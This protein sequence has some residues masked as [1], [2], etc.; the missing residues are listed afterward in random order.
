[1]TR[2]NKQVV[3]RC[4]DSLCSKIINLN[5]NMAS[6]GW[7]KLLSLRDIVRPFIKHYLGNGQE[8]NVWHDTWC[9][10]G[11]IDKF[12]T[13]RQIYNAGFLND[14]TVNKLYS[15]GHL[16]FPVDW[17]DQYPVLIEASHI[18]LHPSKKDEVKWLHKKKSLVKFSINKAWKDLRFQGED[19][20]WCN[21]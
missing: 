18:V 2:D 4:H 14:D 20:P 1:M 9:E 3:M 6:W 11:P 5:D 10:G 8:T 16:Q 19:V 21:V 12:V 13:R 7:N 17:Y 15:N